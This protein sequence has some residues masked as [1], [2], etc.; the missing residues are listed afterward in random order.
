MADPGRA[1]QAN[2]LLTLLPPGD[3]ARL[4]PHLDQMDWPLRLPLYQA[5]KAIEY[6]YFPLS[7]M[8]SSVAYMANGATAEVGLIG[9]E[10]M[11]GLPAL[12][13]SGIAAHAAFVQLAGTALRIKAATL[14]DEFDR[15]GALHRILSRYIEL[16]LTDAAQLAACNLS[17]SLS[18]RCARW[19]LRARDGLG[20]DEFHLTHEFLSMMLGVRRAGVSVAARALQDSGLIRY[21]N[22]LLQILDRPGLEAAACEC[23]RFMRSEAER[24]LPAREPVD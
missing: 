22:G 23:H 10:G 18:E 1:L 5:G 13:E 16:G 9:R 6:A 3:L 17:H 19:L 8:V 24:L 11:L 14:R 21:N 2:R 12:L 15:G 20:S 7:S 4:T